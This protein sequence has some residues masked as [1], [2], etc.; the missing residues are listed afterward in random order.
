ME[1]KLFLTLPT[2]P[3]PAPRKGYQYYW[4]GHQGQWIWVKV[5]RR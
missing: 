5:T 2:H 3:P 4:D 1:L